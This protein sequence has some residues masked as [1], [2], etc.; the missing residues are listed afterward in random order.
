MDQNRA[1]KVN[2]PIESHYSLTWKIK[3]YS[4]SRI[5]SQV[6]SLTINKRALGKIQRLFQKP[7]Q[8]LCF[9][10]YIYW[11][12]NT[13][14]GLESRRLKSSN[15]FLST[16]SSRCLYCNISYYI[17]TRIFRLLNEIDMR[18]LWKHKVNSSFGHWPKEHCML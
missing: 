4:G 18:I 12:M 17:C 2:L 6:E 8:T 11:K 16:A 5:S 13:E 9:C 7:L 14:S 3:D 1:L 15:I 10:Y